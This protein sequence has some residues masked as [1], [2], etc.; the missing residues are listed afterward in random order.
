MS[1]KTK[2]NGISAT[3]R[4]V[5]VAMN[6]DILGWIKSR[7]YYAPD[8]DELLYLDEQI[9]DIWSLGRNVVLRWAHCPGGIMVLAVPHYALAGDRK[10]G[11]SSQEVREIYNELLSTPKQASLLSL[12]RTAKKLGYEPIKINETRN[13][14]K[15]PD[16]AISQILSRYGASYVTNQAVVLFDIVGFS[17]YTPLEQFTQINSLSYSLNI[18][19]ARMIS[20]GQ[21]VDFARS[22][23][24][25]GFYV[26]NREES[27]LANVNLYH[28]MLLALADNAIARS[29]SAPNVIPLLRSA[30]HIGD[31]YDFHQSE[32]LKP[33]SSNFV[34]GDVTIELARMLE[35]AKPG[36]VLVG[37]FK[38]SFPESSRVGSQV[39]TAKF[40]DLAQSGL[41]YLQGIELSGEP[42]DAIRCYLTGS[43]KG[44]DYS[45]RQYRIV[46]KH[47]YSRVAYNAKVNIYR[48][49]A[50][51]IY[52]G[53]QDSE[54][55]F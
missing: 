35:S 43:R 27:V 16:A 26:W 33:T 48:E 32:S 17:K 5:N 53:L 18:A 50:E 14:K 52:L 21:A 41:S 7:D 25:D 49:G 44:D 37:D 30:L 12:Q 38:V 3:I 42:V 47:G 51:P 23:T 20:S 9:R 4:K 6:T 39:D 19:H 29:K 22:T 1:G 2:T 46:D 31:R 13:L 40:I 10:T 55:D 11:E 36:Q 45:I 54:A 34:V 24:G 8:N 28:F 15:K